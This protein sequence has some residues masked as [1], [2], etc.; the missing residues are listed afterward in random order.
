MPIIT[1]IDDESIITDAKAIEE[2][3]KEISKVRN[4]VPDYW[5]GAYE[6]LKSV[7]DFIKEKHKYTVKQANAVY[8]LDVAITALNKEHF[9]KDGVESNYSVDVEGNWE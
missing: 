5:E 9:Y 8:N 1:Y 3:L 4:R 2:F 6:F 7:K